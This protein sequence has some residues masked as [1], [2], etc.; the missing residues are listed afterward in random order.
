MFNRRQR[1][2]LIAGILIIPL[3]VISDLTPLTLG[4]WTIGTGTDSQYPVNSGSIPVIDG[5][6]DAS[7]GSTQ[8]ATTDG[9]PALDFRMSYTDMTL[10]ALVTV[11]NGTHPAGEYIMLLISNNG[12]FLTDPSY[13]IE[14]KYLNINNVTH[15][16]RYV[17]G[18][19]TQDEDIYNMAGAVSSAAV[20][21]VNYTYYEFSFPINGTNPNIY[22][23]WTLGNT[24]LLKIRYGDDISGTYN[25]SDPLTINFGTSPSS[26][27]P[28]FNVPTNIWA[29]IIFGSVAVLFGSFGIYIASSKGQKIV[30]VR[31]TA[32][33]EQ[34]QEKSEEPSYDEILDDDSEE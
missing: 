27:N 23:N 9:T 28:L 4:A 33:S 14:G 17:A 10:Y 32:E 16:R 12:T 11:K 19:Y 6:Q 22:V 26:T 15:D 29:W 1:F 18:G 20:G 8:V 24:Y 34:K 7:W 2:G 25:D 21:G 3:I 13:F 5:V 31:R 30:T